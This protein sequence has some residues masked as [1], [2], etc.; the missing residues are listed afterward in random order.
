M[1]AMVEVPVS[2]TKTQSP[3]SSLL[4]KPQNG[5]NKLATTI[6][7]QPDINKAVTAAEGGENI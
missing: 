5:L 7:Q 1:A 6:K 2:K 4:N 3:Q